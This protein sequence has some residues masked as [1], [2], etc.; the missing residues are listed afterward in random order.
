MADTDSPINAAYDEAVRFI[1]VQAASVDA[2]RSRAA[3][4]IAAASLVTTFLGGQ[5]LAKPS[6]SADTVSY[7]AI[8][9]WGWAA[10]AALCGIA[11]ATIAVM[12]PYRWQWSQRADGLIGIYENHQPSLTLIDAQREIALHLQESYDTNERRLFWLGL[13]FRASLVLLV[14]ESICWVLDLRGV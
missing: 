4:V 13:A 9:G 2:L 11:A 5:A 6:I 1:G 7:A 10:I 12:W 3:T 8:D 14:L